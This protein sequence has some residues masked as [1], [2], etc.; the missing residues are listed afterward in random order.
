MAAGT[1]FRLFASVI[2]SPALAVSPCADRPLLP[3][4]S[5]N[6]YRNERPLLDAL[7]LGYRGA[8]VDLFRVGDALQVGHDRDELQATRT[9]ARL[10]LDPLRD[11]LQKCGLILADSTTFLL[12][13]DLKEEDDAAFR[14]LVNELARYPELFRPLRPGAGPAVCVALVGWWPPAGVPNWPEGVGVQ[15][16]VSDSGIVRGDISDRPVAL[17]TIA[18]GRGFTRAGRGEIPPR[19]LAALAEARR[20]AATYG[21]PVRVHHAPASSGVYRWLLAEGVTLIGTSDLEQTRA[22]LRDGSA[23]SSFSAPVQRP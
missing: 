15:L 1:F 22:L 17:I 11:R 3:A 14:L 12:N 19:A 7:E 21:V 13:V 18:Y 10:Y 16:V 5:H 20:L 23:E 6:D 9:L 8:E 4:Y 2:A